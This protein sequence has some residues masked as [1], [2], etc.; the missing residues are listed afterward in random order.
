MCKKISR[1]INK[2]S[3]TEKET[4]GNRRQES[5]IPLSSLNLPKSVP[6]GISLGIVIRVT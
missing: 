3:L 2:Q 1:E 6:E 5:V 4:E